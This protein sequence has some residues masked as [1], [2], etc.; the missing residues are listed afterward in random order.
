MVVKITHFFN[1]NLKTPLGVILHKFI[2]ARMIL[3]PLN[4][5]K[6]IF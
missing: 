6:S 5:L 2:R 3:T 4:L 1:F